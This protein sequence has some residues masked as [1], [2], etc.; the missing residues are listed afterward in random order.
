MSVASG[1]LQTV[2][3]SLT[4][5]GD[6]VVKGAVTDN[7]PPGNVDSVAGNSGVVTMPSG[8]GISVTSSGTQNGSVTIS[9]ATAPVGQAP[10]YNVADT[11]F[12][13]PDLESTDITHTGDLI[14]VDAGGS[15]LA[16]G[17]DQNGSDAV[18]TFI[19]TF[20]PSLWNATTSYPLGAL[21]KTTAAGG[22]PYYCSTAVT[23]GPP[24]PS[25]AWTAWVGSTKPTVIFSNV[26]KGGV[27]G[28]F[29][30]DYYEIGVD[31]ITR[32]FFQDTTGPCVQ[33]DGVSGL[34]VQRG[35]LTAPTATIAGALTGGSLTVTGGGAS[36]AGATTVTG[37]LGVTGLVT[38]QAPTLTN[39]G[40][41][42]TA[43]S[44]ATNQA[45]CT[46]PGSTA[47][48]GSFVVVTA[49]SGPDINQL[50]LY[51]PVGYAIGP[52]TQCWIQPTSLAAASAD[53]NSYF[54][55]ND[56]AEYVIYFTSSLTTYWPTNSV[57]KYFWMNLDTV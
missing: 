47:G 25:A 2:A 1:Q 48:S 30:T 27:A 13:V 57:F 51:P 24:P 17:T 8:S 38:M 53:S 11:Q 29:L 22:A 28:A 36:V 43:T 52:T 3:G 49:T 50:F 37:T 6:L 21:V 34:S 9:L 20:T 39:T 56:T 32:G 19:D 12:V 40:T 31:S 10:W 4:I 41:V 15:T 16:Y 26:N 14:A 18:S 7:S 33:I 5:L 42:F 44:I 46:P 35:T 55:Y 23:G 45:R 54:V